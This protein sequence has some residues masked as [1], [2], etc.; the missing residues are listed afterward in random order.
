MV[1]YGKL[2]ALPRSDFE[3]VLKK[4]DFPTLGR[5]T[6]PICL[7]S[8]CVFHLTC[9]MTNL[10][11]VP[12]PAEE[13]LLGLFYLLLGGHFAFSAERWRGGEKGSK[14]VRSESCPS[15]EGNF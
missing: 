15:G 9:T 6:I 13:D 3:R 14:G 7:V 10:Q 12:W 11:I 5:P 2:A 4:E 8:Q 1:A